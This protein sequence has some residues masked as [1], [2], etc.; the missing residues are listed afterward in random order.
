MGYVIAGYAATIGVLALYALRTV[1][2]ERALRPEAETDH[3]P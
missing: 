3:G 1:L 2:R